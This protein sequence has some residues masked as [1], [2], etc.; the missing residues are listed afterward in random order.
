M[1]LVPRDYQQ[2]TMSSSKAAAPLSPV[3][4]MLA[5]IRQNGWGGFHRQMLRLNDAKDGT[6]VGTDHTGNK[7]Y[8]N[9][10]EHSLRNRWVDYAQWDFNGSQVPPEWHAWLN[11]IRRDPPHKDP[12]MLASSPA[13]K[14][15]HIEN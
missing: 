4:R 12:I 7:Y 9:M 8:E 3:M 1:G 6:L 2:Q 10:N 5:S 14:S 15:K 11:H 13:W